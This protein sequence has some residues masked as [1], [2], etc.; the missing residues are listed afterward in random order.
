MC[1]IAGFFSPDKIFRSEQLKAMTNVLAHRG[2]DAGGYF[3]DGFI[4]LGHRRLSIIDLSTRAN[5]PMVS[6][7]GKYL[8]VYNG[9]V[10]NFQEIATALKGTNLSQAAI[11][12]ITSSDTEVILE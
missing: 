1:G 7:N 8:I 10:Y 11:N 2:P 4:G 5:Q 3:F 6:L 9:E 12:F